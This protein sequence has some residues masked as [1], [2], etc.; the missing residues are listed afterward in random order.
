MIGGF[1]AAMALG[2]I[3]I[4]GLVT[5]VQV[6]AYKEII[7]IPN[8]PNREARLPWSRTQDWYFLAVTIYYLDGESIIYYLKHIL[9]VDSYFVPL[10]QHHRFISFSLYILGE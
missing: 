9:L 1:F 7:A 4:I 5:A 8:V 3:W 2:H 10:A 6:F